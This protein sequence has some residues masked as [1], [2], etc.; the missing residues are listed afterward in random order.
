[1]TSGSLQKS[2]SRV[3]SDLDASVEEK[4]LGETM[5]FGST[6]PE[7]KAARLI[8]AIDLNSQQRMPD[9]AALIRHIESHT[10]LVNAGDMGR[11]EGM[12][13]S[14]AI[15]LESLFSRLAERAMTHGNTPSFESNMRM[16][17]RAQN[18]ARATIEALI[19]LKNPPVVYARQANITN[20]P[21]QVNN[22]AGPQAEVRACVRPSK[23]QNK[24]LEIPPHEMLD[25]GTKG[26]AGGCN[27]PLETVGK[28]HGAPHR[29]RQGSGCP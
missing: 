8:C 25:T 6:Y 5:A 20:G 9:M 12:L 16:A 1:M 26:E 22:G 18:Q 19:N 28:V 29:R 15:A 7:G 11:I 3:Q 21:Q 24:L 27:P 10:E 4:G 2:S 14:Q 23:A 17:L 13:V